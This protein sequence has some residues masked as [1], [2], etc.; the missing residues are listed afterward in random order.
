MLKEGKAEL[1]TLVMKAFGGEM[2]LK[3]LYDSSGENPFTNLKLI[4]DNMVLDQ[5]ARSLTYLKTYAPILK[6]IK[7][8][9]NMDFGLGVQLD[10]TLNPI[11][12]TTDASG[13]FSTKNIRPEK[14]EFFQT[15]ANTLKINELKNPTIDKVQAQFK[16]ED[17]NLNIKPFDFKINRIQSKLGGKVNLDQQLDLTWNMEI[18]VDMLGNQAHQ[19]LNQFQGQ[20]SKFGIPLDEIKTV[21]VTLK[22]TGTINKPVIK[23]VFKK[24]AGKEGLVETVKESVTQVVETKIEETKAQAEEK[25]NELIKQ[26]EARGDELIRQAE[27]AAERLKREAE[28]QGQRLI[29]EAK[30]PI[31]KYAAQKAADKLVKEAEK[32]GNQLIEK[33]KREKQRLVEEAKKKAANISKD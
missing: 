30:N 19:W 25:A 29:D 15:L 23:P 5:T 22:I 18:P 26:A 27:Q 16:I 21:F 1:N 7:G 32:K 28:K 13:I 8:V 2:R 9:L 31:A 10:Q 6:Q 4:L 3:G 24:G 33:A 17:G 14:V 20:L 12:S 11:L